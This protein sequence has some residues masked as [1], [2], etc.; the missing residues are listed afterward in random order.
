MTLTPNV[1]L[2][3][4]TLPASVN[5]IGSNTYAAAIG[6]SQVIY[7]GGSLTAQKEAERLALGAAQAQELRTEQ[8]VENSVRR[9]YYALRS[10]QARRASRAKLCRSR[11]NISRARRSSSRPES[12]RR[13]T[14][15]AAA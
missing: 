5:V 6:L 10:A 12:S 9:A 3:A 15:C 1:S 7:A 4:I 13:T 11:R 2:G 14:C 8:A